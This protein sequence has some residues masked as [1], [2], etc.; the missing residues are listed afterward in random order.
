MEMLHLKSVLLI[1]A[2]ASTQLVMDSVMA[3]PI[4]NEF[5]ISTSTNTAGAGTLTEPYDAS[6]Q[7]LFDGVMS[8]MP[9]NCTV[10]LLSGTYETLG[11]WQARS[12]GWQQVKSGQ[13]IVG[14]GIDHTT[15][16]LARPGFGSYWFGTP[17]VA[18]T[19]IEV[20]DLTIDGAG[21]TNCEGIWLNGD[22][23][24]VRR[25]RVVNLTS[26]NAEIFAIY[27]LGGPGLSGGSVPSSE[28]NLIEDCEVNL[29]NITWVSGICLGG[30]ATNFAGGVLRHN[31]VILG[32]YKPGLPLAAFNLGNDHDL[33]VEGNYV[34]GGNWGI[35]SEAS[36]TNLMVHHNTFK[37]VAYGVYLF[38]YGSTNVTCSF[39]TIHLA[40]SP[41]DAY[42]FAFNPRYVFRNLSIIGNTIDFY[43][44]PPAR[45]RYGLSA[46]TV[47]GVAFVNNM[48]DKRLSLSTKG[49]TSVSVY[50]NSD[51]D[52]NLLPINQQ[53]AQAVA[54]TTVTTTG[55]YLVQYPEHYIGIRNAGLTTVSLPA[56]SGWS[57]KEFVIAREDGGASFL[58]V[59][60]GGEINGGNGAAGLTISKGNSSLAASTTVI[61]DGSNWFAR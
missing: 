9:P 43:G 58:L 13:R 14:S 15:I 51:L 20:S 40:A 34:E 50:N 1:F 4:P 31:R 21:T 17:G 52:G 18:N 29:P 46:T 22:H 54:R 41:Q 10:H 2:S 44:A 61:S 36:F 33:L 35:Y 53:P 8:K 3:A 56:A 6:T 30:N 48:M 25:V 55:A 45:N 32:A 12:G 57:G 47:G 7:V 60:R 26:R 11:T 37:N 49:S 27:I 24:A 38:K 42:G 19:N 28:G 5:W 39:N 59:S 16:H 23:I